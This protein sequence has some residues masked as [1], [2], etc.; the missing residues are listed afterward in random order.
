MNGYIITATYF[1]KPTVTVP[2]H[3][4]AGYQQKQP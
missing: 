2:S 1:S 4:L 3:Y